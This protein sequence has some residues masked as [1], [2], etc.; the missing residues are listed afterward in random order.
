M[1]EVI[2]DFIRAHPGATEN[3]A[4]EGFAAQERIRAWLGS[5]ANRR[6]RLRREFARVW[7]QME[8]K[9]TGTPTAMAQPRPIAVPVAI[10]E[11]PA[12]APAPVRVSAIPREAPPMRHLKVL[13]ARCER[14]EVWAE[15]SRIRCRRCGHE[16]DNMLDLVPVKPV[17]LFTFLF[18]EGKAGLVAAGGILLLLALLYLAAT[19]L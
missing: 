1:S 6:E 7:T 13:C 5:D 19:R 10:P 16:Y 2:E 12:P 9:S 17:G 14:A 8:A 11:A 18:G 15:G 4:F 3:E